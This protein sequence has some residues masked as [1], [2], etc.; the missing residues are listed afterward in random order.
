M[1]TERVEGRGRRE[2]KRKRANIGLG[3]ENDLDT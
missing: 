2:W 3:R 1:T